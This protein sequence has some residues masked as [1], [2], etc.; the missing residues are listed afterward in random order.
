[1]KDAGSLLRERNARRG[2]RNIQC[3]A[4][5]SGNT[6]YHF[7]GTNISLCTLSVRGRAPLG[8]NLSTAVPASQ[9]SASGI[10]A[11]TILV[12]EDDVFVRLMIADEL[13]GQGFVVVE[14]ASGDE[15]ITVLNSRVE[16]DLVFTDVQMPG[17][18]DGL[19]LTHFVHEQRPELKLIITSGRLPKA[20]SEKFD[21]FIEK[22]YAP[23]DVVER[24]AELLGMRN[25]RSA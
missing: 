20:F 22:P 6:T 8:G 4:R 14:A 24:I 7:G 23:A 15:A 5:I 2:R 16:V 17:H 25:I 21:G 18:V 1:M 3:F 11:R 19:G 13:R 12:V 10:G 9:T